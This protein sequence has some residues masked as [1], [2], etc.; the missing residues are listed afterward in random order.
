MKMKEKKTIS[1]FKPNE[2]QIKILEHLD[3]NEEGS[4]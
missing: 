2:Y 1:N 4:S 3:K